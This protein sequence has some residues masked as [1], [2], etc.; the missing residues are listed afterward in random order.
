MKKVKNEKALRATTIGFATMLAATMTPVVVFGGDT[1]VEQTD[2]SAFSE[3]DADTQTS[4]TPTEAT[5]APKVKRTPTKTIYPN[6]NTEEELT[7]IE[8][9]EVPLAAAPYQETQSKNWVW[10]LVTTVLGALGIAIFEKHL[11]KKEKR[12]QD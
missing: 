12:S 3:Q 9:N 8:D 7:K 1:A 4:E 10:I 6:D 5:K 2:I 11:E